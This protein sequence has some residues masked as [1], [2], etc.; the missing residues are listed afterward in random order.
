MEAAF[1][2][3]GL[4]AADFGLWCKSALTTLSTTDATVGINTLQSD[5]TMKVVDTVFKAG[6]PVPS[7]D[8][9]GN[10][11]YLQSLRYDELNALMTAYAIHGLK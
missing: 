4:D 11:Q 7:V 2:A 10:P 6:T 8:A 9:D 3:Q 1:Q 5:G